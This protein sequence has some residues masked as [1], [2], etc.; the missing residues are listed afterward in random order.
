[1][2]LAIG[3]ASGGCSLIDP[4]DDISGGPMQRADSGPAN[5]TGSDASTANDAK[6]T[7]SDAA[8]ATIDGGTACGAEAEP[9]DDESAASN[10]PLGAICGTIDGNDVDV[11][12]FTTS[13]SGELVVS[14]SADEPLQFT[15]KSPNFGNETTESAGG[16]VKEAIG[17]SGATA[18][19]IV[20]V[21][22]GNATSTKVSYRLVRSGI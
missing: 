13:T 16:S 7:S 1:M 9:N 17:L 20:T 21:R 19:R 6:A 18:T 10:L 5:N 12:R 3:L 22:R 2:T 14:L 4:L 15:V 11:Y 8:D